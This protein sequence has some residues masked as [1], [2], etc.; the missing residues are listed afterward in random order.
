VSLPPL[1]AVP[2][3]HMAVLGHAEQP[4]PKS[5]PSGVKTMNPPDRNNEDLLGQLFRQVTPGS[6]ERDAESVNCIEVPFE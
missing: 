5:R 3:R 4:C 6:R 2:D 1:L